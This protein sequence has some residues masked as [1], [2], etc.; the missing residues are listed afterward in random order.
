MI[1]PVVALGDVCKPKQWPTLSKADMEE[2]GYP[3]FGA[4]GQIGFSST[5]THETPT[6]LVGCRGSCGTIHITPPQAYAN[7]NAMALD[8]LDARRFPQA[9]D[10][11]DRVAGGLA[12]PGMMRGVDGIVFAQSL[13]KRIPN[14]PGRCMKVD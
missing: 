9:L 10:T 13:D 8:S 14:R 11:V 7:G 5:Y 6:L 3:I 2:D 12:G 1:W 4:N